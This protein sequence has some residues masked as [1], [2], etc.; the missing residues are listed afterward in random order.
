M[1]PFAPF[2]G[3]VG[4]FVGRDQ[5]RLKDIG[6]KPS[7][8][9]Q[10]K[11]VHGDRIVIVPPHPNRRAIRDIEGDALLTNLPGV[12]IAVRVADCVPILIA[13]PEG[14]IGVVHSGWRG[15]KE[16]IL[17][18][19]L[20][21]MK[22]EWGLDLSETHVAMGPAICGSCYEVGEDVGGQFGEWAG[23]CLKE[24]NG[25]KFLLD[26]RH[27]NQRLLQSLCIPPSQIEIRPE[28]TLCNEVDFYSYR[29]E[30]RRG[31]KGEGRN[32]GWVMKVPN[33]R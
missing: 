30:M 29:G 25:K 13:H 22:E 23:G 7:D 10:L 32:F 11:Q 16:K 20:L 28:C 21:K 9:L 31:E 12:G 2:P 3:I 17:E 4:G 8:F 15:T 1:I 27:A 14:V 6:L 33:F 5:M 19:A 24:T 18:K 26:L